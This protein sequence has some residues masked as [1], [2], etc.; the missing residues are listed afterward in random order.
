MM[1]QTFNKTKIVATVGPSSNTKDK[2]LELIVAGA[3]VFRLNFSHG[4]HEEHK[5]V[6]DHIR[7]LNQK[8]GTT[9][10]ILQ[11][12]QGPKIRLREVENGNIPVAAGEE[13]LLVY[14]EDP[15]D[16]GTRQRFTTTYDL[17]KDVKP[18]EQILIDDGNLELRVVA[19]TGREVRTKVVYGGPIKS[20]K[21]INL[22]NTNVSEPSLTKKDK[23]DLFFGLENELDW[24]ALS[25]VRSAADLI[26]LRSII[27]DS[28]KVTKI[29][30]KIE[31]PQA[32]RNID[33]IIEAAD[34][35][36]VARG[37]LGVEIPMEEVPLLQKMIVKKCNKAAKPVIIATQMMESMITNPRPTRAEAGDVANAVLDGTD[38]VM[39]SAET[40][41]GKYPVETIQSMVRI[42]GMI[43]RNAQD[44]YGKYY[45]LD[46]KNP[47]FYSS[48]LVVHAC[49]LAK[50]A[51]AKA[52][53]GLTKS[54]YSAFRIASHRPEADIFVFTENR[55]LLTTLNLVW[56]VR[57]FYYE[58]SGTTDQTFDDM[59]KILV[60]KNLIKRG[61]VYINTASIPMDEKRRTN[62][63]KL[64]WVD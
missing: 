20:K 19:V 38:A 58:P 14:T 52:I 15:K 60:D 27:R 62:M 37:D 3:D 51:E 6:I 33:E 16:I 34:A 23:E 39:L 64:N 13:V 49:K 56:G 61:D 1:N 41:S 5:K 40:A 53:L 22:P 54:G 17:A 32:I 35:I 47:N 24:V 2:L 50:E 29:I 44:I 31:T 18:G 8:F 48:N 46:K 9:V 30:A 43:E 28:K 12:L 11:D 63:V 7:E 45:E 36:M 21:G 10:S 59:E 57:C 26:E 25:F 55:N 42:V 4:S